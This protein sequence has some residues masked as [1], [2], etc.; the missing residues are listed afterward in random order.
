M[1]TDSKSEAN[2]VQPSLLANC[3]I[4]LLKALRWRGK[5]RNLQEAMPHIS[6]IYTDAMFCDVLKNLNYKSNR[7]KMRLGEIDARLLPCLFLSPHGIPYVITQRSGNSFVTFNGETESQERLDIAQ[8]CFKQPGTIITFTPNKESAAETSLNESWVKKTFDQ[9]RP[10]FWSSL[11]FSFIVNFLMLSTPIYV[12]N[13]YDRV[14]SS[15]SYQMLYEFVAGIV[16][17]LLGIVALHRVRA[18]M[19]ALLGARLDRAIGERIFERLLYLSP[20]YTETA[21]VG[22]QVARIR[23]FDRVRQFLAGPLLTTFFDVPYVVVALFIIA[24]IAGNLVIIPI[25]MIIIFMIFGLSLMMKVQRANRLSGFSNSQQQEFLLETIN[26]MRAIKYLAAGKEWKGRYR[27]MSADSNLASLKVT[28]LSAINGALSDSI[29]VASGLAVL[30]FGALKI[31]AQDLSVGAMIATMILI[32]R[33]LA[34]IK[35]IFNVL[36]RIHQMFKSLVQINRLMKIEPETE[37]FEL[38]Q[39]TAKSFK[40]AI[41]FVRVSFRY[42]AA[43]DPVLMGV[44]F[45]VTA[46]E[47]VGIVGKNA[48]GKSTVLKLILGLYHPQ[49][50]SV[51]VD[52]QDI[53]QLNPI[54]LRNS[55]SYVSQQPELFYGT[56]EANLRLGRPEANM[57]QMISATKSAGIYDKIMALPRQFDTALRDFSYCQLP[58]SFQQGLCL[59]RAY[60]RR[61]H[62]LLLDEPAGLLDRELDEHLVRSINLCHKK[63]TLMMVSHRPSHLKL[64]DKIM[65]ID[66]GQLVLFGPPG[67]VLPKIPK[68]FL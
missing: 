40:G 18:K 50:G 57:E 31:I 54:E 60:L 17:V 42:K 62:I 10:L 26:E 44:S 23:D 55:I 36:P 67:E 51:L 13:V 21:T 29:M 33:V 30:S 3:L 4:P 66:Q 6:G 14:V 46:G 64:C 53:R 8:P 22:S 19:I 68:D 2:I 28:L 9:N 11:V 47:V 15:G 43:M 45:D 58:A 39:R 61:S 5:R 49:A 52:N 34:P 59:A 16:I 65:L 63:I 38:H 1:P 48:S 37:A 24:M 56:I 35:T 41:S 27:T 7:L 20:L 12:M 32:W 25:V